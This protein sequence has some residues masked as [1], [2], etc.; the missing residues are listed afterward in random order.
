MYGGLKVLSSYH[1]KGGVGKT[2]LASTIAYLLAV[3]GPDKK[4]KKR[5]VEENTVDEE[6]EQ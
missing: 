6:I 3:G 2:F 4:G 5:K 1:R